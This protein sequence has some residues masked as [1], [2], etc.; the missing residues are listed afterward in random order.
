ME[1]DHFEYEFQSTCYDTKVKRMYA[2][3]PPEPSQI[4]AVFERGVSGGACRRKRYRNN[5]YHAGMKKLLL[6]H[7]TQTRR[8]G[9]AGLPEISGITHTSR[10]LHT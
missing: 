7:Q 4:P 3:L 9:D 8:S 10:L 2:A 6:Q 1:V 5:R